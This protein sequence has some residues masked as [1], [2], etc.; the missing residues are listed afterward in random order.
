MK[1]K[2]VDDY[3]DCDVAATLSSLPRAHGEYYH[4]DEPEEEDAV[5]RIAC[6]LPWLFS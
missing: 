2:S 6:S 4:E 1:P 5:M 3:V